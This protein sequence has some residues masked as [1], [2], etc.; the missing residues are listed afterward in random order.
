[1]Y[2]RDG[3]NTLLTLPN[4][5]R[6]ARTYIV[7][8]WLGS[9]QY[10]NANGTVLDTHN[11]YYTDANG[12]YDPS[13]HIHREIDGLGQTHAF[14]YNN[15]FELVAESHPDFSAS[16]NP[17]TIISYTCD[18]NGNRITKTVPGPNNTVVTDYY[19]VDTAN[20]LLRV[21]RVPNTMPSSGQ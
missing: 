19:Q 10:L 3:E 11:Y 5:A 8:D 13:G 20:K 14:L 16:N 15:R 7:R 2:D 21:N 18:K 1:S 4:N 6:E 9:I 12:V 17:S